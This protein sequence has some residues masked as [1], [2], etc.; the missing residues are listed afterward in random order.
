MDCIR[1]A[2]PSADLL[3]C[4]EAWCIR[5]AESFRTNCGGLCDDQSSRRTLRVILR[6]PV[7]RH[8]IVGSCAHPRE[9]GHD[10]AV[11]E[12]EV[13]HSIRCEKRLIRHPTNS[14]IDRLNVFKRS[15]RWH[16]PIRNLISLPLLNSVTIALLALLVRALYR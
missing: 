14:C 13:S 4:P 6:L 8:M 10:D 15:P 12:I 16:Q 1:D 9:R 7:G 11:R 5:P 2:P 3:S